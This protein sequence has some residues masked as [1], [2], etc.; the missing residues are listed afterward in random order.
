M[1]EF[2]KATIEVKLVTATLTALNDQ[3]ESLLYDVRYNAGLCVECGCAV[4]NSGD[5]YCEKC[6]N[7]SKDDIFR[8]FEQDQKI[9]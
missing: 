9:T 8:D 6:Y 2:E 3:L 4:E 1:N 5:E 7:E